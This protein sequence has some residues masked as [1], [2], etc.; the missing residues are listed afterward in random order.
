M[1]D[2]HDYKAS[3]FYNLG[4]EDMKELTPEQMLQWAQGFAAH[5]NGR[6]PAN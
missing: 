1:A 5:F 6:K 2:K 3:D 4:D